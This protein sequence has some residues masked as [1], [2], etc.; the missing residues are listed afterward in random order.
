MSTLHENAGTIRQCR[1]CCAQAAARQ[2]PAVGDHPY[3]L[4]GWSMRELAQDAR[5]EG[6]L[7]RR[8]A[9]VAFLDVAGYS[10][11]VSLD[12]EA[13]VRGW[14]ALRRQVVEPR[15][16]AWRGRVVDHAGVSPERVAS[17]PHIL[18][19]SLAT[20]ALCLSAVCCWISPASARC[21]SCAAAS[22]PFFACT[23]GRA[24]V[25]LVSAGA[26][27][28]VFALLVEGRLSYTWQ[29]RRLVG[30]APEPSEPSIFGKPTKAFGFSRVEKS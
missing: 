25:F 26:Q 5:P 13:T 23:R 6:C 3:F 14:S 12:E 17:M 30:G 8:L 19:A 20:S 24:G 9:A 28:S 1:G 21:M 4:D 15:V 7:P 22:V 29:N 16:T 18:S 2:S 10:R 11:L 27:R